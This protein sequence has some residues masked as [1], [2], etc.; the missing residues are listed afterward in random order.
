MT[1]SYVKT[2]DSSMQ[3]QTKTTLDLSVK[4]GDL[5]VLS[6]APAGKFYNKV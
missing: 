2:T 5:A 6:I 1:Q 4:T 3:G